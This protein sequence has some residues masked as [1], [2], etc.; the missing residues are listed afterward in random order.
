MVK[1]RI[2][3]RTF[4]WNRMITMTSKISK[5]RYCKKKS[6]KAHIMKDSSKM[7]ARIFINK[8]NKLH[9]Q[10]CSKIFLNHQRQST[11]GFGAS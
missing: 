7:K 10:F 9:N 1:F 11:E 4:R 8:Q 2:K 6:R 3:V 5:R